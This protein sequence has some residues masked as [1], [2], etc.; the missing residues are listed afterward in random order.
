M[1]TVVDSLLEEQPLIVSGLKIILN[2]QSLKVHL[3]YN[4]GNVIIIIGWAS[5][6]EPHTGWKT[7][8]TSVTYTAIMNETMRWQP[9]VRAS[10]KWMVNE[11]VVAKRV[12]ER[13]I[14][15]WG[16]RM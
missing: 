7:V 3:A 12:Y 13:H 1:F 8:C 10:R 14:N 16:T 2:E 6:S 9:Y 5:A 4:W 15:G 11:N